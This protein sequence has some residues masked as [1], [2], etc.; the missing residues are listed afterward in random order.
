MLKL[1]Y[2][3][4]SKTF[5]RKGVW[6]RV[7]PPAPDLMYYTKP[8]RW[9]REILAYLVGVSLGDGN[10]SKPNG[11]SVRLSKNVPEFLNLVQPI[12]A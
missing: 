7:P 11:R 2:K 6:V 10:L 4:V 9:N 8:I 12:K 3:K 5:A 1:V